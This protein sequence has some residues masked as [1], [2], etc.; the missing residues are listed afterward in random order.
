MA[1]DGCTSVS[2]CLCV[3]VCVC[4]AEFGTDSRGHLRLRDGGARIAPADAKNE[5][6]MNNTLKST[7]E[8]GHKKVCLSAKVG[9]V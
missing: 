5:Q 8:S 4:N 6:Q 3:C 7:L 9:C 1:V 2:V